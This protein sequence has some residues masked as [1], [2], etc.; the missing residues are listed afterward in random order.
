MHEAGASLVG[1]MLAGEQRD[2]KVIAAKC[3]ER[4]IASDEQS[5]GTVAESD[6]DAAY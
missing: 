2:R 3:L 6:I 4:M 1:D 5:R